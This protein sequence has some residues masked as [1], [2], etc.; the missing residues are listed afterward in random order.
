[1]HDRL[2][3]SRR[4]ER[5]ATPKKNRERSDTSGTPTDRTQNGVPHQHPTR[6]H[7]FSKTLPAYTTLTRG[8]YRNGGSGRP[9]SVPR[10]LF[11]ALLP[12]PWV[13][14]D[15]RGCTGPV[16]RLRAA[17]S[18]SFRR[19]SAAGLGSAS[20]GRCSRIHVRR[21]VAGASRATSPSWRDHIKPEGARSNA[22]SSG[23]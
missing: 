21:D 11:W 2:P 7:V 10:S 9:M 18:Q 13:G 16:R 1:M 15:L 3:S 23:P 5:S 20:A 14:Y 17:G 4:S 8:A 12:F 22:E 6:D 19:G